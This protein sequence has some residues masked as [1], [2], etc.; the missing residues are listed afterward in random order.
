MPNV[1]F[2]KLKRLHSLWATLILSL[3]CFVAFN[4]ILSYPC[5]SGIIPHPSNYHFYQLFWKIMLFG[6]SSVDV[7]PVA[8]LDECDKFCAFSLP[9]LNWKVFFFNKYR[10]NKCPKAVFQWLLN[11]SR[12]GLNLRSLLIQLQPSV[13]S[14][15]RISDDT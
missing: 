2:H 10:P 12:L 13:W 9:S 8:S 15:S 1:H 11:L 14:Q 6:C 5:F 3:C 7:F 4:Y